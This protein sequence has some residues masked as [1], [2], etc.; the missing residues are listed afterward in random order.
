MYSEG[1]IRVYRK[2]V[3]IQRDN[4]AWCE[5][6]AVAKWWPATVV[7]LSRVRIRRLPS[8]QLTANLLVGCHLR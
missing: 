4:H 6:G 3:L 5:G 1:K 7:L 2:I 8:S